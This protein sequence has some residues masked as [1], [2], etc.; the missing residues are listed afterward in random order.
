MARTK[1]WV[2]RARSE[3][4]TIVHRCLVC[5][6][7]KAKTETQL[8]GKL[9]TPRV[10]PSRPFSHTGIDYAG[11]YFVRSSSGRGIKSHKAWIS[12]FVC[13]AVKA[14]HLE[15]VHDYTTASFIAAFR[16]FVLRRSIPT[17]L[18]SDNGPNFRSADRE[19]SQAF[20]KVREDPNLIS[21]LTSDGTTWHFIPSIAPH[22][23]GLWEAGVKSV[24]LH[25]RILLSNSTPTVE[26]FETLLCQIESCLNSWPLVPANDDPESC[27]VLT[28][29]HFLSGTALT[30]VP[31][32]SVFD[33]SENLLSR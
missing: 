6:R 24:K 4:R 11:P 22:F 19:L 7:D 16:R 9:P 21:H 14:I 33:V 1:Y 2:I 5:V 29:G 8:M 3:V 26:E 12:I 10:T 32:V 18:Y 20:R 23:G 15:L 27:E 17:D 30:V 13:F 28:P 25:L 31:T